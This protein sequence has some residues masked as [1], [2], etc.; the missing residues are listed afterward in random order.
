[1]DN[2][3]KVGK[4]YRHFKGEIYKVIAIGYHSETGEK[5]VVYKN[6]ETKKVCIR[7]YDMF[8]SDVDKEKYP[9]A[10]QVKRFERVKKKKDDQSK[11]D[12]MAL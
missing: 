3:V 6:I 4:K 2:I 11:F 10:K 9:D 1:M 12:W 5:M 7:P 8:I